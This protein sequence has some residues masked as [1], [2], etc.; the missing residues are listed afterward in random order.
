MLNRK[1]GREAALERRTARL[2]CRSRNSGLNI[3]PLNSTA[4]YQG[5][6]HPYS[7]TDHPLLSGMMFVQV[8]QSVSWAPQK[9][10]ATSHVGTVGHSPVRSRDGREVDQYS[11]RNLPQP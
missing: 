2:L 8:R 3:D 10:G 1:L 5:H 11:H 6:P 9:D 7:E 4:K